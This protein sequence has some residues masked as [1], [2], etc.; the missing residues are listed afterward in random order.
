MVLKCK[1]LTSI[2]WNQDLALEQMQWL[3]ADKGSRWKLLNK[4]VCQYLSGY[5]THRWLTPMII[6]SQ[7]SW[8]HRNM[9]CLVLQ[10]PW[11][12]AEHDLALLFHFEPAL[13]RSLWYFWHGLYAQLDV[14]IYFWVSHI[15]SLL[16]SSRYSSPW[17]FGTKMRIVFC[18]MFLPYFWAWDIGPQV[19]SSWKFFFELSNWVTRLLQTFLVRFHVDLYMHT[20]RVSAN[21]TRLCRI[22]ELLSAFSD[23]STWWLA[24]SRHLYVL[25]MKL[26]SSLS[27]GS[28]VWPIG[29]INASTILNVEF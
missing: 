26:P 3:L 21:R 20:H 27:K 11:F 24:R 4:R 13:K 23:S 10:L 12:S 19:C 5:E 7:A 14:W 1:R 9:R 28:K 17:W 8:S 6:I 15:H 22:Q 2:G 29:S 18:C 16:I 25:E